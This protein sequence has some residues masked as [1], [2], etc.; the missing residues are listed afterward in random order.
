MRFRRG[1]WLLRPSQWWRW[2]R[3]SLW[4]GP[5]FDPWEERDVLVFAILY[6]GRKDRD[7]FLLHRFRAMGYE[8]IGLHMGILPDE[9][10][11]RLAQAL[12]GIGQM[13][14][15]IERSRPKRRRR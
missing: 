15:L 3:R 2:R 5:C 13:T 8:S 1:L 11:T 10:T 6:L 7:V 12:V 14:A 4:F 9:V